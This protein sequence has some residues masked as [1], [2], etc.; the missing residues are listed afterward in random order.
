M[1]S[2]RKPK[3]R[4]VKQSELMK[5]TGQMAVPVIM[6]KPGEKSHGLLVFYCGGYMATIA[7]CEMGITPSHESPIPQ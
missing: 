4:Q 1:G 3:K 2:K 5:K 6:E 7:G